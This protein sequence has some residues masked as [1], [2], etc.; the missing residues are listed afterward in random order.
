M[1]EAVME[2]HGVDAG[3]PTDVSNAPRGALPPPV[4]I[5]PG[6]RFEG[7]LTFRGS[8]RIE[9]EFQGEIAATGRLELAETSRVAGRV[10]ADVIIIAGHFDGELTGRTRVEILATGEVTGSL[11]TARLEAAEGCRVKAKYR[12]GRSIPPADQSPAPV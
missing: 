6:T 9:G 3:L 1:A 7:T 5:E 2:R 4:L 10:E 11:S 8:T 12:T